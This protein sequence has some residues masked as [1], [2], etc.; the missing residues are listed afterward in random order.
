MEC[1]CI[2]DHTFNR[3]LQYAE[4]YRPP[5]IT[6]DEQGFGKCQENLFL[7][8]CA[9]VIRK[10]ATLGAISFRQLCPAMF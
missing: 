5:S 4:I 7:P 1:I 2:K 8:E 9:A 6:F 10:S 3:A